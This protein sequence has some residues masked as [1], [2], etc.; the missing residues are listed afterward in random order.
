MPGELW[1]AR[2]LKEY[3]RANGLCYGCGEKYI[4]GHACKQSTAP[5]AQLKPAEWVDPHEIISDGVLDALMDNGPEECATISV[6]ALSGA[7]HP[8]TVQLRAM[9]GNQVALILLDSGSTHTFVDQALLDRV[10][11]PTEKLPAPMQVKVADGSMVSC[12]RVVPQL[13]WWVQG[14]SFSSPMQVLPLGGYDI[15]LGMDWLEQRGVM[16]CQWAEKWIQFEY[17]G[18]MVKL[19][20]VKSP[21]TEPIKEVSMEQLRKWDKGNDIWATAMLH[22]NVVSFA[23]P[24]PDEVQQVLQANKAVFQDPKTLPPHKEFDHEI[25]LVPGAVPV[26]CRPYRYSPLQKDEIERQVNEMLKAGLITPSLS[27]FASP[28]LQ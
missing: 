27:L 10:A 7:S 4:P 15:I 18:Q 9:V 5:T 3:R 1:K 25:H 20:G 11:V 19:Q 26:N 22:H 14:H 2:Q 12:T 23:V 17:E 28:V 13:S 8:K 6:T 24:I 16:Q 21:T